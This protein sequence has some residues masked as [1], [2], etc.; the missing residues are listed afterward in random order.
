MLEIPE[1]RRLRQEDLHEFQASRSYRVR[2]CL[3]EPT[4]LA[5]YLADLARH[6]RTWWSTA[7]S[8]Q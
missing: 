2:L 7:L 3:T 6:L 1:L 5:T 4:V 8:Q